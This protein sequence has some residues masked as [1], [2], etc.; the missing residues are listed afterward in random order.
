MGQVH[1]S[2]TSNSPDALWHPQGSAIRQGRLAALQDS[3]LSVL[4]AGLAGVLA[5]DVA[6]DPGP[7]E[8]PSA[9]AK[10]TSGGGG[11]RGSGSLRLPPSI[12]ANKEPFRHGEWRREPFPARPYMRLS[13]YDILDLDM[14]DQIRGK[15]ST[16]KAGGCDGRH[17]TTTQGLGS[18]R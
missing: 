5:A 3:L 2:D 9:T 18:Y 12:L 11:N 14:V 4:S 13:E 16:T 15:L 7:A 8:N 10:S 6:H 17:C 1:G